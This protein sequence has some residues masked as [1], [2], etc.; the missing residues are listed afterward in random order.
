MPHSDQQVSKIYYLS[1]YKVHLFDIQDEAVRKQIN[2]VLNEDEII[3][4][5][6]NGILSMIFDEIK[7]LNKSKKHLKITCNNADSQ[8][9][10]N[11]TI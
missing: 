3:G 7:K 2:Y 4:K 5:G 9:K 1:I 6:L 11:V 10:N 8:N